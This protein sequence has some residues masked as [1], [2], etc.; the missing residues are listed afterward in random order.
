MV[1]V[2]LTDDYTNYMTIPAGQSLNLTYKY[3]ING[4]DDENGAGTNHMRYIRNYGPIYSFPSDV[5]SLTVCPPGTAYPNPGITA[6]NIQEPSYGYLKVGTPSGTTVPVTWLG[7]PGVQLV[8]RSSL[9][10]GSWHANAGTDGTQSTNWPNA[11]DTQFFRLLK[12]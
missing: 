8:N 11:G 4:L 9:T 12:Q 1:E 10:T 2:G 3:S 7:R 6:T 5:W